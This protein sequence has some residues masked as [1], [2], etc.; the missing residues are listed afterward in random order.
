MSADTELQLYTYYR[1]SAAY[2]VRIA[3]ALKQLSYKQIPINLLKAEH[4]QKAYV[5]INRQGLVPALATSEG[6]VTQSLAIIEY[7]DE[8]YPHPPLLPKAAIDRAQ[9]RAMAQQIAMEIHP[10]NNP[11]VTQFLTNNLG[12]SESDK[13]TWY[14]HWIALGFTSLERLLNETGATDS[15]AKYCFGHSASV[16]DICLIPQVYNALRFGCPMQDYPT[17]NAIAKHC[18]ALPAFIAASP[19][20]QADYP[21]D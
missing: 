5:E 12:L 9:V 7:L 18:T 14:R 4:K 2:R 20:S 3:L 8:V 17:I 19:E 10:L 1:S 11:K 15:E 13:L 6:V 21:I 16:A